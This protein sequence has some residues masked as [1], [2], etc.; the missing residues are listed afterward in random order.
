M[1]EKL[2]QL[3][4]DFKS[5]LPKDSKLKIPPNIFLDMDTELVSYK[6]DSEI[7]MKFPLKERYE[8]PYGFIQGGIITAAIDNTMGAL[9]FLISPIVTMNINVNFIRPIQR[10]DE[11]MLVKASVTEKTKNFVYSK[12]EVYSK[13]GK[14][15]ASATSSNK[16]IM[17]I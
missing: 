9:S 17:N 11:F 2:N 12:A 5:K 16:I 3:M 6:E 15:K 7:I 13:D 4:M 14:I 1:D 10:K 8:N